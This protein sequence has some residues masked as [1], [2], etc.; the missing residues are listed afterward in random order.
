MGRLQ[1][2]ENGRWRTV[3]QRPLVNDVSPVSALVSN[4]GAHVVTFDNW[5]SIGLGN[6]VVVIY[7]ADGNP[8]RSLRLDESVPVYI[9][10]SF[11]RSVSSLYWQGEGTRIEGGR[12]HL[13]ILEPGSDFPST[14]RGFFIDIDLATGA[15]GPIAE[16]DLTRWRP[17]A[18][19]AHRRVVAEL[20]Q[21]IERERADLT[22][23]TLEESPAW[24]RYGFQVA[25]RLYWPNIPLVIRL[26]EVQDEFYS[27]NLTS[28][29]NFLVQP[30]GDAPD[31]RVFVAA[32][33]ERLAA[34]IE[35]AAAGLRPGRLAG[36]EMTFIAGSAHW[37]RIVAALGTSGARLRQV[38]PATPLPPQSQYVAELPPPRA[39][40]PVCAT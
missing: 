19:E 30:A 23:P 36:V 2:L 21:F 8:V 1:V 40:D 13:A 37:P 12:L 6:N 11:P 28:F 3:W 18:C 22:A 17:R 29:R 32:R 7:G 20:R 39:L 38:D 15:V 9:I 34:E 24:E 35:R 25:S 26:P 31:R 16:A 10:D 4:D 33:Q 14:V 5:H 27:M